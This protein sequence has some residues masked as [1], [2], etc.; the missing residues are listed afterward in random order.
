MSIGNNEFQVR[1]VDSDD[2]SDDTVKETSRLKKW[3][4]NRNQRQLGR[5]HA[6]PDRVQELLGKKRSTG[7]F[8]RVDRIIS[9]I[10]LHPDVESFVKLA[11]WIADVALPP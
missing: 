1:V 2:V 7:K 11:L 3:D 10:R 4:R 6:S 5:G 9:I 8:A